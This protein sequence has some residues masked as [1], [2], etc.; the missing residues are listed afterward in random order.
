MKQFLTLISIISFSAAAFASDGSS[1]C[2]P[3]WYVFKDNSLVSSSLRS[4]TNAVLFPAVTIGMTSGTSNCTK[5]TIVKQEKESLHF[6]AHNYFELKG[7]VTRGNGPHIES[8]TRTLGCPARAA[9]PLGIQLKKNY[10]TIFSPGPNQHEATLLEV[11]NTI[12][13]DP[14]LSAMCLGEIA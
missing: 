8:F 10:K 1:G 12:F 3:G 11:Y 2:G 4:T 7:Q 5:H 9:K 6:I 14:E 13:S